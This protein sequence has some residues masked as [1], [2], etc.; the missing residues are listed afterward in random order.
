RFSSL[1]CHMIKDG[2]SGYSLELFNYPEHY[3]GDLECVYIPHGV[4][5]LHKQ[6]LYTLL[7]WPKSMVG[8]WRLDNSFI[9]N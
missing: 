6:L 9:R 1:Q 2:W 7:H 3:R 4:I 8:L 5:H